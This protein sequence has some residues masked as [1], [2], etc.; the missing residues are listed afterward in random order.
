MD[1]LELWQARR[2][3]KLLNLIDH[4][5]RNSFYAQAVSE[6]PDHMKALQAARDAAG[7]TGPPPPPPLA[8]WS[9]EVDAIADLRDSVIELRDTLIRVNVPKEGQNKIPAPKFTIRPGHKPEGRA[10]FAQ[11]N[12]EQ[13]AKHAKLVGK[14]LP[15]KADKGS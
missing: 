7:E 14:L 1:V 11:A 5:P 4:L 10:K 9:A 2:W 6:D 15:H 8:W 3:R 13:L 12:E